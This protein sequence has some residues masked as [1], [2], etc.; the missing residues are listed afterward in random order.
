MSTTKALPEGPL[1]AW[2]GDDFTGSAAVMEVL[3]FAGFPAVLFFDIPTASQLKKFAGYRGIGVAGVSRSKGVDWMDQNLPDIYAFLKSVGARVRH[4][5]VCSTLDSSP[6]VGSIGRAVDLGLAEGEWAPL[7]MGAPAIGR[8]QT[9][10]NLF[11]QAGS[12]IYRLDR[13]PTM[14]MHPVTPMDEGDV[15][16]HLAK[17]TTKE[18]G[19]I[20]FLEIKNDDADRRIDDLLST[21]KEIISFDIIDEETLARVGEAIWNRSTDGLFAIGSQGLEYALVA[22]WQNAGAQPDVPGIEPMKGVA[23]IAAISGSCSP[24]TDQ[25]ITHAEGAGFNVIA[26][27]PVCVIDPTVWEKEAGRI[28]AESM[29]LVGEGKSPLIFSA[30]GPQDPSI[31]KLR[32]AVSQARVSMEDVNERLGVGMGQILQKV[33]SQSAISRAAIA[34]GDTSSHG[35]QQLGIYGVEARHLLSPGAAVLVGHSDDPMVDGLEIVLK[36]GQMGETDFFSKL[37]DG[38]TF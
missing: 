33:L 37:R 6:S 2:Y 29:K 38:Q 5:K 4:Y 25:Q 12:D 16:R 9:F 32:A 14:S 7:V 10:G 26:V 17:Q 24:I 13:H 11:A 3:S 18:I 28:V 20:N 31:E 21:Q 27:D 34:G 15:G 19:L 23:Q 22:G 8:Y 30:R 36:G 1:V 35:A